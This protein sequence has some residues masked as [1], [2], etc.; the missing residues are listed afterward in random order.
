MGRPPLFLVLAFSAR[1]L[2]AVTLDP[3][4]VLT[5]IVST[6]IV[7]PTAMALAPDGRIFVAQ[8]AGQVRIIQNS[9][10]LPGSALSLTVDSSGERGLIGITLDP[11]FA[12]NNFLYL[13]YTVPGSPAHNRVSRF[14][15]S[16]NTISAASETQLL[17]LESLSGATNHNGGAV[18]F[19]PD[20]KLYIGVGENANP[21]NSQLLTNRLGKILRI[22]PDGTIPG[23]NPF[24]GV[25]GASGE[26]YAYG[27]RN[28]FQFS[29]DPA[30]GTLYVNDV[31]QNTFEEIDVTVAG[32]NYGWPAE[33]GPG[34]D[35]SLIDPLFFYGHGNSATTGCAITG[36]AVSQGDYFFADLCSG[37]I[38]RLELTGAPVATDFLQGASN[39]VGLTDA[40]N[41]GLYYLQRGVSSDTGGVFLITPVAAAT[42]EPSTIALVG[43]GVLALTVQRRYRTSPRSAP[44]FTLSRRN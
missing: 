13:H 41:N 37:W 40:P 19:G 1:A 14:T 31:G 3:G 11:D 43:V 8:Q 6:G 23:N 21:A 22:N 2:V 17:N 5:P 26:I 30:A 10:L 20:G 15:A 27:F 32:G 12:T 4:Y 36:G 44:R 35:P 7:N 16:G 34:P 25:G 9:T 33:E 38:R 24:V 29:F 42:P 28:P 18:K 39:I